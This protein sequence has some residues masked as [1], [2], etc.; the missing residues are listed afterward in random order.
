MVRNVAP[1]FTTILQKM[2]A[3]HSKCNFHFSKKKDGN[4]VQTM[5]YELK[6]EIVINSKEFNNS[7][8]RL[9]AK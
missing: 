8:K 7:I 2:K 9:E 3:I 4:K 6:A 1:R 5:F